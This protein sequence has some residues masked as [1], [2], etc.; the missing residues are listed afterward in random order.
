MKNLLFF[1]VNLGL[2]SK[3]LDEHI[4]KN[5][6]QKALSEKLHSGYPQDETEKSPQ[7]NNKNRYFRVHQKI[8]DKLIPQLSAT[9]LAYEKNQLLATNKIPPQELSA[10]RRQKIQ[11]N[12][13][14]FKFELHGAKSSAGKSTVLSF[15]GLSY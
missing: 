5:F 6:Q 14:L 4:I 10:C 3:M 12:S 11:T 8:Y 9:P 13:Q 1:S 2:S 15:S 7:N